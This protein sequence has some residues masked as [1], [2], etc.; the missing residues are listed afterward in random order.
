MN[1]S[2][3][4]FYL[5]NA[6]LACILSDI[7]SAVIVSLYLCMCPGTDISATVPHLHD[8]RS[9]IPTDVLPF[10]WQYL[11]NGHQM[12]D[13][14]QESGSVFGHLTANVSKTVSRS[15][16]CRLE[17]NISSMRAF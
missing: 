1:F 10:R 7:K 6:M 16:T 13:Q 15:I 14:T 12:R 9:V 8:S 2:F 4:N 17:L 3:L 11:Y 5:A